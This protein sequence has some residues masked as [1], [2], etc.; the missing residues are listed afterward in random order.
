PEPT[1]PPATVVVGTSLR[2][3]AVTDLAGGNAPGC[4]GC[5]GIRPDDAA[6]ARERPVARV[7]VRV[8]AFTGQNQATPLGNLVLEP[9]DAGTASGALL[10]PPAAAYE[11]TFEGAD[12]GFILCPGQPP[13][14]RLGGAGGADGGILATFR[15]W[16]GCP[17]PALVPPPR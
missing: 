14:F 7:R 9:V 5:D 16:Q 2:V 8:T 1:P 15:L 13:S 3:G 17:S 10:V 6:A 11:V 12:A 4:P